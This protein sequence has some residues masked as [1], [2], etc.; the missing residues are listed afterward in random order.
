M[1]ILNGV[2]IIDFTQ[3]YPGPFCTLQLADFGAEVI[4]IE[5]KGT[6]DTSRYWEPIANGESGF[7]AA[8]NRN[9]YSLEIDYRSEEGYETVLKLIKDADIIVECFKPGTMEKLGFKVSLVPVDQYGVV[10]HTLTIPLV[11]WVKSRKFLIAYQHAFVD[12]IHF[13]IFVKFDKNQ[14]KDNRD[15]ND[16]LY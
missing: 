8:V 14:N 16:C 3:A 1:S 7:Y 6:G 4:K 10:F 12:V 13:D 9:K 11:V 5:R 15:Y 2:K